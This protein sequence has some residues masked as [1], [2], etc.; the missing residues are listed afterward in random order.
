MISRRYPFTMAW[1]VRFN[2]Y[3]EWNASRINLSACNKPQIRIYTYVFIVSIEESVWNEMFQRDMLLSK[4]S[5]VTNHAWILQG[6][7]YGALEACHTFPQTTS[8]S[9]FCSFWSIY[10]LH[11]AP[12][13]AIHRCKPRGM[14]FTG[15]AT[16]VVFFPVCFFQSQNLVG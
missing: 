15:S 9:F 14:R 6:N 2:G 16:T 1:F 7:I 5:C 12:S 13:Q 10:G 4:R 8:V 3:A 11:D